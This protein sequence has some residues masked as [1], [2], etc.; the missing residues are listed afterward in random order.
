M[1]S[2]L[3]VGLAVLALPA[4]ATT[5]FAILAGNNTG[6]AQRARLWFAERDADR[7]AEALLELGE[8]TKPNV[9]LT[10]G[11]SREHLVGTFEDV[12]RAIKAA[13]ASGE[14]TLLVF[15]F[16]GHASAAGLELGNE[17]LDFAKVRALVEGSSADLKVAIVDA[18]EAGALTQVKG[19]RAE[20]SLD[21]PLPAED[22]A[23]GVAY[24]ASTAVG[25]AAQESA[26]LGSSFF[27]FHLAAALRGAGDADGDGQVTLA[28][29]FKYTSS[30]TITG[31]ST[32][33]VGAQHPT[34]EFRMSGRGDVVLAFR[35]HADANVVLEGSAA[36]TY[37]ISNRQGL[38]AEGQGGS[39][40]GLPAGEY[41]FERREGTRRS[42]ATLSLSKGT[43]V[44]PA[45]FV[46]APTLSSRVKGGDAPLEVFAGV[47][48]ASSPL[49]GSTWLPGARLGLRRA[50]FQDFALR[51]RVDY[52]GA[53]GDD[54]GVTYTLHRLSASLAGLYPLYNRQWRFEAGLEA[55]YVLNLQ[56]L[57]SGRSY[58]SSEALGAVTVSASVPVGP[59]VLSAQASG[60]ARLYALNAA[61]VFGPRVEGALVIGVEL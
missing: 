52:S 18:C 53:P 19:A 46:I 1:R 34:Y 45:G 29:A 32:T 26:Q 47:N 10:K 33:T 6:H 15:Y 25:E 17:A 21:F 20:A 16:S 24:I 42:I 40:L 60:G 37:I 7:F 9:R 57:S 23:K 44:T 36:I 59:V 35:Q 5:R 4:E 14:R 39:T 41:E 11:G 22:S 48:A 31:T 56:Q 58:Q 27:T 61:W 13:K 2:A 38:V 49:S 3:L 50:V 8:F 43:T 55:G 28:E 54:R 51:L 12:E 30:R